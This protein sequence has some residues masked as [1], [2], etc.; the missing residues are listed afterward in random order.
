MLLACPG[1]NGLLVQTADLDSASARE[2]WQAQWWELEPA[3]GFGAWHLWNC[4]FRGYLKVT[5]ERWRH[6]TLNH[7]ARENERWFF[8]F[9]D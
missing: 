6:V 9:M 8:Q 4:E 2:H 7:E 5:T 1:Q 3:E